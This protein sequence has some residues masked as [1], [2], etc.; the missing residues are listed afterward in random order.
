MKRIV[1]ALVPVVLLAT[2]SLATPAWEE[3]RVIAP[4]DVSTPPPVTEGFEATAPPATTPP[5]AQYDPATPPAAPPAQTPEQPQTVQPAPAAPAVVPESIPLVVDKSQLVEAMALLTQASEHAALAVDASSA[6]AQREHIQEV[7]TIL[8][9]ASAE[10]AAPGAT[11]AANEESTETMV[12][13]A[14]VSSL[15]EQARATREVAEAQWEQTL[16]QTYVAGPGTAPTPTAF[17]TVD[18]RP[19]DQAKLL[20]DRALLQAVQAIGLTS[21]PA[22]GTYS[23]SRENDAGALGVSEEATATMESVVRTL[24]AAMQIVQIALDR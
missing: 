5:I 21:T 22:A 15:L 7:I 12:A 2:A 11:E 18:L 1:L 8:T 16:Q 17:G 24:K 6:E 19:E 9:G 10:S 13:S 14:G 20:V 4:V 23:V 3:E